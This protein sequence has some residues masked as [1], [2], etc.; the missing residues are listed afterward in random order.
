MVNLLDQTKQMRLPQTTES[1]DLLVP[2]FRQGQLVYEL[3]SLEEIRH[4]RMVELRNVADATKR[5]DN[6]DEYR[7]GLEKSLYR[8]RE[9]LIL[10]HRGVGDWEDEAA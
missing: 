7:V 6:P 10:E 9:N 2:V 1:S 3:P 4:R 5:F 8:Q